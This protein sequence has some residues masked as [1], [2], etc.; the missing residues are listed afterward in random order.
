MSSLGQ[1][2][3]WSLTRLWSVGVAIL[4]EVDEGTYYATIVD[5]SDPVGEF[6]LSTYLY[7]S[8][9]TPRFL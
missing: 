3:V 5:S 8:V 2:W 6:Y 4:S 9:V 7:I 1:L